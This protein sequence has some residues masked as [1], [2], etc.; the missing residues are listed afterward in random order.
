MGRHRGDGWG[1]SLDDGGIW[2]AATATS[3]DL[4]A[5]DRGVDT[6]VG[7]ADQNY[8]SLL[9]LGIALIG[10]YGGALIRRVFGG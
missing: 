8:G 5:G 7:I 4:G 10:A 3:L 9:A 1:H 6:V 2:G